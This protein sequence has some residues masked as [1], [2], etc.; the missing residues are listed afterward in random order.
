MNNQ[1]TTDLLECGDILEPL[2]FTVTQEFNKNYL[3]A[4]EDCHSRYQ[5]DIS[6]N[7]ALVHT[8]LLV[9]HSNLTRSPSFSLPRNVAAIH[10]HEEIF[11]LGFPRV[12]NV[13]S[14]HWTVKDRYERRGR[15]F[16]IMEAV[17]YISGTKKIMQRIST[18]TFVGG[19]YQ[20]IDA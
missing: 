1:K 17:I 12:D 5:N 18:N 14:V 9:N 7:S 10:S 11:F 16:Q 19:P 8:G 13:F 4:V 3:R 6:G 20:N 2:E 15:I